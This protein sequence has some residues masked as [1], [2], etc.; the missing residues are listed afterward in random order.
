MQAYNKITNPL[1]SESH[2]EARWL[3]FLKVNYK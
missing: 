2:L 3:F 1:Y